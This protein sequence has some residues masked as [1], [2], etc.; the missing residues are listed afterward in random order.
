MGD[1]KKIL[2][3]IRACMQIVV[4]YNFQWQYYYTFYV[5][6]NPKMFL[7]NQLTKTRVQKGRF[8]ILPIKIKVFT[9]YMKL[10]G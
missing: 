10:L 7:N 1:L 2:H 6:E 3:I 9:L 8:C 4:S 5:M